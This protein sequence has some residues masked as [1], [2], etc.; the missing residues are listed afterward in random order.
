MKFCL[1]GRDM[2]T[3]INIIRREQV[4]KVLE[5]ERGDEGEITAVGR[6][7]FTD[8]EEGWMGRCRPIGTPFEDDV[9][10][11][12]K[13]ISMKRL[14]GG[15]V[16][17]TEYYEL[18]RNANFELGGV[19]EAEYDVD[20]SCMEQPLLTHPLFKNLPEEEQ[21]ALMAVAG[22]ATPKDTFSDDGKVIQDAI[23]SEA[24]KKALEKLR[25]GMIS[26]LS[27]GGTFSV[28]QTQ[29]SISLAGVGKKG[30]PAAGA[31]A[32]PSGCNWLFYG[33]RGR[34]TGGNGQWRV[35]RTWMVSGQGG[36][37]T[38]VY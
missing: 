9:R 35:T 18:P 3:K 8:V 17:V 11:R 24:G 14:D 22:G 28:T 16:E 26:F 1:N 29:G 20:Y 27:P 36:W 10:M 12:M 23:K 33:I 25:K 7:V 6:M 13:K 38:D 34:K 19:E 4:D 37:D 5:V 15:M 30:S 2:A 21:D 31:P 32:V